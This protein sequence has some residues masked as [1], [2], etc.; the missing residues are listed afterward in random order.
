M[1]YLMALVLAVVMSGS[2]LASSA[3]I[4]DMSHLNISK[5]KQQVVRD[6]CLGAVPQD[7]ASTISK[8]MDADNIK[9]V[10]S[11]AGEISKAIVEAA[12][13]IGV[14]A[15]DFIKT[16]A[17][18]LVVVAI[19]WSLF[20]GQL[21]GTLITIFVVWGSYRAIK[22]IRYD[23]LQPHE[24]RSKWFGYEILQRTRPVARYN[25]W[26]DVTDGQIFAI[27]IGL[28]VPGAVVLVYLN[29]IMS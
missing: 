26:D 12:A 18:I 6:A 11:A 3:D 9:S 8:I 28:I 14:A 5:L 13:G 23:G 22:F 16:P 17:G 25:K 1:K 7:K 20:G 4:C 29:M 10:G 19:V 27:I 15:S 24:T 21:L 2:A